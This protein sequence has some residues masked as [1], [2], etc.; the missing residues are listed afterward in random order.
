ML[1]ISNYYSKKYPQM[2]SILQKNHFNWTL[3]SI[4]AL[5]IVL[6]CLLRIE[7][8][9]PEALPQPTSKALHFWYWQKLNATPYS[10][11]LKEASIFQDTLPLIIPSTP[12][13]K[14]PETRDLLSEDPAP[15]LSF[16]PHLPTATFTHED[17]L[18][19]WPTLES[20]PI[21]DLLANWGTTPLPDFSLKQNNISLKL[22]SLIPL[23]PTTYDLETRAP[24]AQKLWTPVTYWI[25][26]QKG[27]P[28]GA[29]LR[30]NSSA[31]PE[32]DEALEQAALP[33]AIKLLDPN[34]NYHKAE[35]Y[36]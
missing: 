9:A 17:S 5:I 16:N 22:T 8:V 24:L 15:S 23:S 25:H 1:L 30:T 3:S 29:P 34:T 2:T 21:P 14:F 10:E 4:L 11:W 20:I 33:Q 19:E 12:P 31:T 35:Y 18:E 26:T 28:I 13:F 27:K 36:P 32:V 6:I 7:P